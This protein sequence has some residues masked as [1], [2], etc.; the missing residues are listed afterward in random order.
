V[1]GLITVFN[2]KELFVTY[3]MEA[4][5]KA[6]DALDAGGI[7]HYVRTRTLTSPTAY[8]DARAGTGSFGS[9]M[10]ASYEYKI[11][12]HRKDCQSAAAVIGQA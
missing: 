4:L 2:R 1:A 5:A 9:D 11:Y 6:R 7:P 8:S 10:N 12:V 3:S